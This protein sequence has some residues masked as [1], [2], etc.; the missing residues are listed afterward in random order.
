M[1]SKKMIAEAQQNAQQGQTVA[2]IQSVTYQ[3]DVWLYA[4][5]PIIVVISFI[6]SSPVPPLQMLKALA[7]GLLITQLIIFL[8]I[9]I[10]I[11]DETYRQPWLQITDSLWHTFFANPSATDAL[12]DVFK[13]V[14]FQSHWVGID[15]GRRY[16]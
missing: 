3:F 4:I 8:K 16:F 15:L 11:T 12:K 14:G 7:L 1:L 9:G 6:L 2:S 5:L 10:T 13:F